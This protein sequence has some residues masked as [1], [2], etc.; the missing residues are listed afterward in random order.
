MTHLDD[1]SKILS[2]FGLTPYESKVYLSIFQQGLTTAGDIAKVAGIRREEVYR[3]LPKLEKTGLI[4][5][6]LGRPARVRALPIEDA[7][8]ILINRKEEEASQVIRNLLSKKN[9]L[10]EMFQEVEPDIVDEQEKAHFTLVSEK[11]AI[12]KRIA[13]LIKQATKTIDFVDTFENAFRFVLTFAEELIN[14]NQRDV[15][16]RIITEYPDNTK[17]IPDALNKHVPATSFNIRYCEDLPG[18]YIIYDG[19][20]ALITTAI[21]SSVSTAGTLW[22]D[23]PSLVRIVQT[24]FGKLL[25]TSIDWKDL[26]VTSDEKLRR[27]LKNLRPRDHVILF[28]ESREAK[29]KTLFSYIERGLR[30]GKAG[31]YICSEETPEEIRQAMIEFGIDVA[32]FEETGALH[33][34]PYTEMYI[35][36]GA[37]DLDFVMDT[38]NKWYNDAI[39]KG[40]SGMRATGE[41]SCFI[42]HD[43]ID[44]LI[45]YEHALHTVLDIPMTA[46]C[47]YN[48]DTLTNVDNPVDVYSE[49]V[50]AH[51]KVL[52]A[53]KDNTIGKIEVRAG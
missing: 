8:S 47:A 24:D 1:S 53:G 35:R 3:T 46:I 51:G 29:R 36:D 14:A 16:V 6:V 40:F 49:L 32:N 20:Q 19:Y 43:L 2:E 27:I 23:D 7:L 48:A 52:F 31:V 34:L 12:E 17:L 25:Q 45:D 38:W 41:M 11:D 42:E 18:N 15:S 10:L 9:Q 26:K 30:D 50:K 33:V 21:G 4:E 28:Y 13:F 5:R 44:D 37:F 22:T 39:D